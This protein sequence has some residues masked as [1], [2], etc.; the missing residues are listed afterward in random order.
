MNTPHTKGMRLL[1]KYELKII[2]A[3][4][5]ALIVERF[6]T[7]LGRI[8]QYVFTDW[9]SFNDFIFNFYSEEKLDKPIGPENEKIKNTWS[10]VYGGGS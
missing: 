6:N 3:E 5:D 1:N 7:M 8:Q 2:P 10:D 9:D 4:N